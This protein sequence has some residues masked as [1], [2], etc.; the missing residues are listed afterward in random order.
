[1]SYKIKL[2]SQLSKYSNHLD[3]K[4]EQNVANQSRTSITTDGDDLSVLEAKATL[5]CN[6]R[7]R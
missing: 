2:I 3:N 7:A 5:N 6:I 1:M 4:N